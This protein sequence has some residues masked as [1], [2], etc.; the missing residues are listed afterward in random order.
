MRRLLTEI[1]TAGLALLGVGEEEVAHAVIPS[2]ARGWLM[3]Q[4]L[5]VAPSSAPMR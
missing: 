4:P 1:P 2:S 3:R 5:T